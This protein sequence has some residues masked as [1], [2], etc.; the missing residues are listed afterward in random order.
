MNMMLAILAFVVSVAAMMISGFAR[1]DGLPAE[2]TLLPLYP[3]SADT[4]KLSMA[5]PSCSRPYK[6]D[7]YSVKMASNN[8]TV[9]IPEQIKIPTPTCTPSLR[10]EFDLGRLPAGNYTLTVVSFL[11]DLDGQEVPNGRRALFSNVPIV[12]TD[13]RAQKQAP[14]VTLDYT[15]QWWDPAD[16]G[17]G[18]FIWQDAH[19]PNDPLLAAWFTYS[20]DG[21]ALWYVFQPKFET[22]FTTFT[23]DL[24]QTSRCPG[25]TAPPPNPTSSAVVG[26]AKLDFGSLES[27]GTVAGQFT[28]T[29]TLKGQRPRVISIQRFAP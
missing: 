7:Y 22:A 18:L 21:K 27:L 13:A 19:D 3:T 29:V 10:E 16:P 6:L 9:E 15:G 2:R 5:D 4:L 24:F 14:W 20:A 12:V 23:T 28:F 11:V 17:S 26:T 8:I 25:S 1:A